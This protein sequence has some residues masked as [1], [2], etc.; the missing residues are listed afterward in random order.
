M[1]FLNGLVSFFAGQVATNL[2]SLAIIAVAIAMMAMRCHLVWIVSVC[3]GIWLIFNHA[4]LV[5]SLHT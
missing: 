5:G 4:T 1:A 3:S 2:G